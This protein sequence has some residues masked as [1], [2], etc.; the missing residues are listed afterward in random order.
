MSSAKV[1]MKKRQKNSFF[2][3]WLPFKH[4]VHIE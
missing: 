4:H 1:L 2:Y 3:K